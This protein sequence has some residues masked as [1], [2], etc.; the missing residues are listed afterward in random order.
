MVRLRDDHPDLTP[1]EPSRQE[2]G[3]DPKLYGPGWD[4]ELIEE[5]IMH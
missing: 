5:R 3:S 2:D 4:W 1:F